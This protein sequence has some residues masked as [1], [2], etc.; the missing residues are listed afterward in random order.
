MRGPWVEREGRGIRTQQ[1]VELF[2]A[3]EAVDR[4]AV[5]GDAPFEGG[6]EFV[7]RYRDVLADAEDI[8]EDEP[9]EAH[10]GFARDL[11]HLALPGG[12]APFRIGGVHQSQSLGGG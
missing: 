4:A 9:D 5:E 2:A 11:E 3:H 10:A 7:Y 8:G 6:L 12:S 1:H